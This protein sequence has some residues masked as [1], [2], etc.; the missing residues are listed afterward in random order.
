MGAAIDAAGPTAPAA[1][2]VAMTKPP[3]CQ[4]CRQ[5]GASIGSLSIPPLSAP[6]A[7]VNGTSTVGAH[8]VT[9]R[10][11]D[12]PTALQFMRYNPQNVYVPYSK[13][14]SLRS[15]S[16]AFFLCRYRFGGGSRSITAALVIEKTLSRKR[17]REELPQENVVKDW[18]GHL[19]DVAWRSASARP[20]SRSGMG[21]RSSRGR[22]GQT[23]RPSACDYWP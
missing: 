21:R 22:R 2:R 5:P 19:C 1:G 23:A 14:Y 11:Q 20:P 16:A 15:M 12:C 9:R 17:C 18:R 4:P 3:R 7:A 10:T 8:L 13:D 6:E